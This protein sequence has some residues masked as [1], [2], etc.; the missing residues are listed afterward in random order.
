MKQPGWYKEAVAD[1]GER[2]AAGKETP[3]EAAAAIGALMGE[4]PEYLAGL[5]AASLAEWGKS[6]EQGDLFQAALFPAL[7]AL[8]LTSVGK[9][10]RVASM[11]AAELEKAKAM[12]LAQTQNAVNGAERRRAAFLAFYDQVHPR[13]TAGKTVADVLPDLAAQAA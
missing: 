4:R 3:D 1:H 12:L 7:P 11:T 6:R 9:S 8:L 13:L 5:A 10:A 2:V